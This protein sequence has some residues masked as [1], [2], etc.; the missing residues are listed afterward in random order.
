MAVAAYLD[1]LGG[2]P[3]LDAGASDD[4]WNEEPTVPEEAQDA[5]PGDGPP[6]IG[7]SQRVAFSGP[8]PISYLMEQGVANPGIIS[9]A[10]GLVDQES[11]PVDETREVIATILSEHARARAALQ[12]GTSDG[13]RALRDKLAGHLAELDGVAPA[14]L[15]LTAD[16]LIVGTGSQQLLYLVAETLLDPG[17][18]VLVGV[19]GYFVFMGALESFGAK[20]VGVETDNEGLVLEAL[21]QKLSELDRAG[22]LDRVKLLYDVTYFNNPTG[23]SLS[24]SRREKLVEMLDRWSRRQRIFLLEDAAYRELRYWGEDLPSLLRYDPEGTTVLYAGTFS[25]PFAP[26]LK[27]GYIVVPAALRAPLM[28]QKGHHDF[29][30]ANFSQAVLEAALASGHYKLHLEK[31][32]EVYRKKCKV[33]LEALR[34]E[35][36]DLTDQ[37]HWTEPEG[38]LYVWVQL[39]KGMDA[40]K[41][42]ELF[43]R[44]LKE[45]VLYVP[46]EFCYPRDF[47]QI[48]SHCLRLSFG[49]VPVE[50]IEEG[51]R[52]LAR[53]VREGLGAP[54]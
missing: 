50:R 21:D 6:W 49:H 46:G 54:P 8:A 16:R 12:Y 23:L 14:D 3:P 15:G 19:P 32:R 25:K 51:T 41:D 44:C 40:R 31:L 18:I 33:M 35:F 1:L 53:A 2:M 5:R 48:P 42:S 26:G 28:Q 22:L 34:R 37:V 9:L 43:R 20:L 4:L 13:S 10:A 27:T 30:S 36:A 39:P 47:A 38:G 11:L 17:D 24:R 45:G 7:F 52:R 29:G